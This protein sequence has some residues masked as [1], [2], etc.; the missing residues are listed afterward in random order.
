M[1]GGLGAGRRKYVL[2]AG[3]AG[4]AAIAYAAFGGEDGAEIS[5]AVAAPRAA[6]VQP[7]APAAQP[8][9]SPLPGLDSADALGAAA[10]RPSDCLIEPSQVVRVNSA[11]EGIIQ[12]ISV[13]RGQFVQ[14]G[15]VVAQLRSDVEQAGLAVAQARAA[16]SYSLGAAEARARYLTAKQ[17]R[18]ERL[19]RYLAKDAVEEAQAN[20]QSASMQKNEAQLSLRVAQLEYAQSQRLIAE[21]TVRSPVS[22]IVTERAMSPGEYRANESSHILTIAQIDPLYVEV[23]APIAQLKS[24]SI[25]DT[26]HVYPEDPVGGRYAARVTVIDRVFDAASGTFGLRLELPNP[27]NK[28]PAGLRCRIEFST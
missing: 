15:Q 18:S 24:V 7:A 21:R 4:I 10:S 3:V 22:G 2:A 28:L 5:P 23:F 12:S 14:R 17:D 16:N 8:P 20:A 26:A 11:V 19:N 25:G 6:A 27:G 13:D 1:L 9:S